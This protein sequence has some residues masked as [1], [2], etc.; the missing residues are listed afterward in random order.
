[1]KTVRVHN[2]GSYEQLHYEDAIPPEINENQVLIKVYAASVNHL[3]IKGTSGVMKES[4]PL[5]FPWIPGYDFAGVVENVGLNVTNLIKG[6]K[7]YGNC[8]GGSY[9]EY[10]AADIHKTVKMPE[11]LTFAEASSVPHVGETAWQALY[12]HGRLQKGETVLIHG[13]AGAV[14]G[15]AIQFAHNTGAKVLST[16]SGDDIP[17]VKSLGADDVVDFRTQDFASIFKDVDLVLCL[18]G[19]NVEE[20][21]YSVLKKRGKLVSTVGLSYQDIAKQKEIEAIAMGIEQS[22]IDLKSI[23]D[24]IKVGKV[25]TDIGISYPLKD[26]VTAWK[27]LAGDKSVKH[28]SHGKIILEVSGKSI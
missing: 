23:T 25:K 4:M 19:G 14:G 12:K 10:L 28:P 7:V 18:V 1:M 6:D 26:V 24:L 8:M 2:Y 22:A 20:K 5:S 27:A 16:A 13:G 15:F 3:E 9:A 17:F 21:S 11:N